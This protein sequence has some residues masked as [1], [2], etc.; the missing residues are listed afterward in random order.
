M[1]QITWRVNRNGWEEVRGERK[2]MHRGKAVGDGG[3]KM[4]KEGRLEREENKAKRATKTEEKIN[5]VTSD[6]CVNVRQEGGKSKEK[7]GKQK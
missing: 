3:G 5:A 4:K 1:L 6:K 2:G 7:I